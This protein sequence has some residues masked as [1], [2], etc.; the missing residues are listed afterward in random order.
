MRTWRLIGVAALAAIIATAGASCSGGNGGA[1][2]PTS[3]QPGGATVA[4]G[5]GTEPRAVVWMVRSSVGSPERDRSRLP[6]CPAGELC[7]VRRLR[8]E[9]FGDGSHPWGLIA[10]RRFSCATGDGGS[11][12]DCRAIADLRRVLAHTP[13]GACACPLIAGIRATATTH[14]DGRRVTVP[15]DSCTYCGRA[16][17]ISAHALHVLLPRPA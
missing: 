9:T 14:I 11:T 2:L 17:A 1:T 15:L 5:A 8:N 12:A 4:D 3:A 16:P 6:A 10:V 7:V 13:I